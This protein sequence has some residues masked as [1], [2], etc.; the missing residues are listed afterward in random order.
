[1]GSMSDDL[2][3]LIDGAIGFL[4]SFLENREFILSYDGE[5]KAGIG[6]PCQHVC[7][8]EACPQVSGEG[9]TPSDAVRDLIMNLYALQRAA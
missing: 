4:N 1:M 3:S 5:W 7:L 6:N 2:T 9:A 8:G